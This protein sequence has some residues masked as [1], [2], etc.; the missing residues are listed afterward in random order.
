[1]RKLIILSFVL[2]VLLS[3]S[4]CKSDGRNET[5]N[6][7]NSIVV[8]PDQE[9]KKTVN[10]YKIADEEDSSSSVVSSSEVV[11]SENRDDTI[12]SKPSESFPQSIVNSEATSSENIINSYVGSKNTKKFHVSNCRYA[13]KIK[14]ENAVKFSTTSEATGQ[15]YV[16]CSVCNP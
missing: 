16:P 15:G 7:T 8:L 14:E 5:A 4:S 9:T 12:V 11:S 1:M 2:M 13:S 3:F 6:S 10:G